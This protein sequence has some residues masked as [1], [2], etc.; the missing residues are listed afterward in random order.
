MGNKKAPP[1]KSDAEKEAEKV[2]KFN[3]RLLKAAKN[4]EKAPCGDR[5]HGCSALL[6]VT[7]APPGSA[8]CDVC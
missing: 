6:R 8:L 7:A 4:D 2:A 1:K 3:E 5:T